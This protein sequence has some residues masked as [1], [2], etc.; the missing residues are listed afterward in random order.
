MFLSYRKEIEENN[1]KLQQENES[2]RNK[3][4]DMEMQLE[5]FRLEQESQLEKKQAEAKQKELM[6][7]LTVREKQLER[8]RVFASH[9]LTEI[10]RDTITPSNGNSN[11]VFKQF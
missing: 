6:N 1:Q 2:L 9:L 10:W 3:V 11:T 8:D 7:Q 5:I 4:E